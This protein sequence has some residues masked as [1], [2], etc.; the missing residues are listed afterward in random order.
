MP[1]GTDVRAQENSNATLEKMLS[2]MRDERK[3]ISEIKNLTSA[4]LGL[5]EH[6]ADSS[7]RTSTQAAFTALSVFFLGIA[8]VLFGLRLTTRAAKAVGR[9]FNL[10]MWALTLPVVIMVAVYQI[11]V[12]TGIPI[13][14]YKQDEPYFFISALLFVP[15]AIVLF[16]LA[17]QRRIM[18]HLEKGTAGIGKS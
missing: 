1:L 13:A 7:R 9:Y 2:V 17:A 8:L 15:I 11:G 5:L 14:I 12:V 4:E 16:L 3:S 18:A 6:L 10:M